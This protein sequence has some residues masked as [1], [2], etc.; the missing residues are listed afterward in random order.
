[1]RRSK[2]SKTPQGGKRVPT[3]TER[4]KNPL[5]REGTTEQVGNLRP[6]TKLPD[7]SGVSLREKGV[8]AKAVEDGT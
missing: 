4:L 2:N 6:S 1:M 7:L 8:E 3:G 5:I